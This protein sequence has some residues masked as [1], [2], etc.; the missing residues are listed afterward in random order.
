MDTPTQDLSIKKFAQD[1][2]LEPV[3]EDDTY[4][5]KEEN[6]DWDMNF[7]KDLITYNSNITTLD[8]L[9]STLVPRGKVLVRVFTK[10]LTVTSEGLVLPN[11]QR[12]PMPTKA[13][14]GTLGEVDNPYVYDTKAIVV[15]VPEYV[16]DLTPGMLIQMGESPTQGVPLGAGEGAMIVIPNAFTHYTYKETSPPVDPKDPHYG[17][18]LVD[19]RF[20]EMILPDEK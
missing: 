12:V 8:P 4:T 6:F 7:S 10:E 13:G 19:S 18:L 20:I 3:F 2:T 1:T 14:F 5:A 15:A 16:K 11:M 17:Y 9:Y